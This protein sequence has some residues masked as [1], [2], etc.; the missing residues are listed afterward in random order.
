MT[1]RVGLVG[2]GRIGTIH[3]R[4]LAALDGV[5]LAG[6]ADPR[7]PEAAVPVFASAAAL[8]D[9]VEVDVVVVATPT[10]TH[11]DVV[12]DLRRHWRGRIVVE[13]PVAIDL[14]DVDELLGEPPVDA[15][16]HA[17]D[18]PEVAWGAER[19][20]RWVAEHGPIARLDTVLA[21]AYAADLDRVTATLGDSW[22]DGGINALSILARLVEPTA[23]VSR[24]AVAAGP[25][26][27][28]SAV[29]FGGPHGAGHARIL[30]TWAAVEPSK[31]TRVGF[32][33]GA[34][35]VLD[36]QAVL[37][38]LDVAGRAAEVFAG[39]SPHPRLVQHYLGSFRRLLVDAQRSFPVEVDRRLHRIL[40][41]PV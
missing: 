1:V 41:D 35:A 14:G 29:A 3:A 24:H 30:T 28:E 22:L 16:Y 37:A 36:H 11:A 10:P 2:Y 31:S 8:L 39:P 38:R 17:A 32:A 5:E 27:F 20:P 6:V 4:A 12:R 19:L 25:S 33:D 23:C 13:K 26:T 40:L 9:G 21:D 15:V 7:R 34:E 18:G